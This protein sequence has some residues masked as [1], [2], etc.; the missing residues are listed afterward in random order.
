MQLLAFND[1]HGALRPVSHQDEKVGGAA[2][3]AGWIRALSEEN[4]NTLVLSA[5][6]LIGG[7]PLQSALFHDEPT[8]EA[9]NLMGVDVGGVGNHEFDEGVD[10]LLRMTRGGCHPDDGCF[11]G[12]GFAGA[13]FPY[14]AA[15]VVWEDS[16][17]P[18]LPPYTVQ[19]VRGMRVGFI[20]V[21]LEETPSIVLPSGIEDVDF[22]DESKTIKRYVDELK[23]RRVETIVV[24]LHQ[25]G[26]AGGGPNACK[27]LDGPFLKEIRSSPA[28]VDAWVTG[29]THDS[30]VCQVEGDP[31]T[32]AGSSGRFVT[33]LD[34]TISRR[35]K[36]VVKT[37]ATN[38]LTTH[39]PV[40]PVQAVQD[41]VDHY[42][43][44]AEEEMQEV[45]GRT[46]EAIR[47]DYDPSQESPLG[48]L[49]ADSQVAA[50]PDAAVA[51]MN[52]G[53]I[54]AN[55]DKGP[56]TYAE[57]FAIL[58]FGNT[59]V[60]MDVTGEQILQLLDE[61]WCG[62]EYPRVLQVSEGFGYTWRS[63]AD[64]ACDERVIDSSVTIGGESLAP[65]ATYRIVTNNFLAAGGDSFETFTRGTNRVSGVSA[66][67]ALVTY[68]PDDSAVA[69][70]STPRIDVT[71]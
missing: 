27:D 20:G 55:L 5:G 65:S 33:E 63:G 31:V 43:S 58:P 2:Y 18:I 35:T 46:S 12:D 19:K 44:L 67:E 47:E 69:A 30:F 57:A 7:S 26:A 45:I 21:T 51:F 39:G 53:G 6:D 4:R 56:V 62:Q 1:F 29:H 11:G 61:Q 16:R 17:D 34:L 10:E 14:L 23:E 68:L 36:D 8:I 71:G 28:E 48:N 60:S 37:S 9:A 52:P 13:S 41:L 64:V 59:L 25:G 70:P 32:M 15:N 3:T 40:E 49:I 42:K 54:R 50:T 66:L 22:L 38:H 24:L